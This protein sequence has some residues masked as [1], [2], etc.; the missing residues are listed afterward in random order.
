MVPYFMS[1]LDVMIGL[2]KDPDALITA[3]HRLNRLFCGVRLKRHRVGR[4]YWPYLEGGKG[5][6]ILLI[7]GFGA[8]KD[9]FGI[10][11]PMI[12]RGFR[13]VVPDI[14]GFG[15]QPQYWENC[16]DVGSQVRR[17]ERFIESLGLEKFHLMGVSLGGYMAAYYAAHNAHRVKSLCL[18]DSAGFSSAVSSD[19]LRL[20]QD[21]QRN[22]FMPRDGAQMQML[23]DYLLHRPAVLPTHL[24]RYWLKR[25]LDLLPWRQKL[26]DDLLAGGIYLMDDLAGNIK[27][28][29]LVMW[30]A[31]DRICHVST[32]ETIMARIENCQAC[33]IHGCGHI[34]IVEYPS[35]SARLYK[36][37]LG[38]V[39]NDAAGAVG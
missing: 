17:I 13:I 9:R 12:R 29:T 38:K 28:P 3:G 23:M 34:P 22:I 8:D 15:D 30:G 5:D 33:I 39:R 26:F 11:L 19:A 35:L 4:R 18:M 31:E 37:F 2:S 6:V 16:Y 32:V 7:H 24:R 27:V 25:T 1:A 36:D 14:P 20:F 10:F 21:E